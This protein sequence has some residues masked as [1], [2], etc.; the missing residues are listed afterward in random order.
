[1]NNN[2]VLAS[3]LLASLA[4][5]TGCTID[6]GAPAAGAAA[7]PTPNGATTF[8]GT[9]TCTAQVDDGKG[10][11]TSSEQ[12]ELEL[13]F[14]ERMNW[15]LPLPN[16]ELVTLAE[17]GQTFQYALKPGIGTLEVVEV[18]RD[19]NSSRFAFRSVE[20]ST[21]TDSNSSH[22][23]RRSSENVAEIELAADGSLKVRLVEDAESILLFSS[24]VGSGE[25]SSRSRRECTGVLSPAR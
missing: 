22:S 15:I 7:G 12:S 5:L 11:R 14:D 3:V 21:T 2:V 6:N 16:G 9:V 24:S 23:D 17:K 4:L 10:V 20:E 8:K 1:M 13:S 19:G 18:A 25:S